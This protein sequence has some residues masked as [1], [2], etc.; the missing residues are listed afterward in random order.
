M[1]SRAL[2][3]V[4]EASI[5]TSCTTLIGDHYKG[6]VRDRYLAPQTVRATVSATAFFILGGALGS[7][8][9]RTPFWLYAVGLLLAPA[10]AACLP[11][12]KPSTITENAPTVEALPF[13]LR[14]LAG[15]C[16]VS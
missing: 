14:R 5:M 6:H 7:S 13:P 4:A 3:G 8:D 2:L 1:I 12:R 16:V 11:G 9:W 15:I 10:M